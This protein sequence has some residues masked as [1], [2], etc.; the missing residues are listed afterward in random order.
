MLRWD[1]LPTFARSRELQVILTI[2]HDQ[3][4]QR[5]RQLLSAPRWLEWRGQGW[6]GGFLQQD[7]ASIEC[8]WGAGQEF[9]GWGKRLEN[10][11]CRINDDPISCVLRGQ[12]A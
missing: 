11:M 9:R 2:M 5:H 10:G 6:A 4:L 12:C 3:P 7:E 1:L 8:G